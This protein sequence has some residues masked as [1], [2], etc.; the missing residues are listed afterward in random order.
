MI[1]KGQDSSIL[2]QWVTVIARRLTGPNV[3]LAELCWPF[4]PGSDAP[5]PSSLSCLF[6]PPR[7]TKQTGSHDVLF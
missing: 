7:T 6:I 3:A 2:N 1:V 4:R 5:P